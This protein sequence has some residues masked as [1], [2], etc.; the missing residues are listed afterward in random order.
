MSIDVKAARQRMS[1]SQLRLAK[2]SG[3]SRFKIGLH[4]AGNS[5]LS[6][7]ELTRIKAA[8]RKEARRMRDLFEKV[9][10]QRPE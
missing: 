5:Q 2:L 10:L 9:A 6:D 3:V 4:E 8:L 1:I 7:Q